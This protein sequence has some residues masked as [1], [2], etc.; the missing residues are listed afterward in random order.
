MS[1]PSHMTLTMCSAMYCNTSEF[2]SYYPDSF[3]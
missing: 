1:S 3:L 2:N